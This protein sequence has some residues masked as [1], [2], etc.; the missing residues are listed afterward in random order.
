MSFTLPELPYAKMALAP[1]MSEE[2]LNY[3]YGKHHNAY[4]TNLNNLIKETKFEKMTLEEIILSSEGPVFNNAAQIWNHTFFWNSLSPNGGGEATGK[5]AELITK[6][7]G[8]FEAFKEAFTK[9]AVSN[10]GAGWTWLALN[11]AGEL[12]VVNTSNAQTPIT[13]GHK[14]LIT[15]DIWE[16]AYYIDYRNERPKFINAFWAL[17]NWDFANKNL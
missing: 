10:F 12:E 6:K 7:W 13:T 11:K 9:S 15:V 16:H 14:P 1:H 2:T 3:H 4:V 17:V 8:S 5:V